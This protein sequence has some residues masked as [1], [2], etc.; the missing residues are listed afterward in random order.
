LKARARLVYTSS[1]VSREG[2]MSGV[3]R[4]AKDMRRAMQG[5]GLREEDIA[6]LTHASRASIYN[7]TSPKRPRRPI[8]AHFEKFYEACRQDPPWELYRKA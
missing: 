8:R 6:H 1:N 4:L 5:A 7:W 3:E 2:T